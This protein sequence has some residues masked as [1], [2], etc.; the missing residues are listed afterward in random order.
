[1]ITGK[2]KYCE[3]YVIT[4][5]YSELVKEYQDHLRANHPQVWLRA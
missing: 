5:S 4:G 1:M 3:W 2:C